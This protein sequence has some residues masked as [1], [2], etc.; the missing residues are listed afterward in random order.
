M[1]RLVFFAMVAGKASLRR[2]LRMTVPILVFLVFASLVQAQN[3]PH[4]GY[5]YTAG[6]RQG[7]TFLV[8]V[9]GQFPSGITNFTVVMDGNLAL[10]KVVG[11]DRPLK[12]ME[13]Q[14]MKEELNR[15]QEKRK[16]GERLTETELA[17]L[18]QIKR[19]L[20]Q[21]GR[22]P[23]NPAISEFMTLQLTLATNLAPGD[24][25]IRVR[26]LGGLSNPLKFCVGLLP[27]TSKPDWKALPKERG[28]MDP[29]LPPPAEATVTLPV[30]LNGQIVPGGADRYHFWA[31]QGQQLVI[32][33]E[34][35]QL[36]P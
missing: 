10:A 36:I 13:Q 14:A 31:R 28:S 17:R 8:T 21:F 23:A 29:A 26:A 30:T 4:I 32:A 15:F 22:R 7:T 34:A 2:L 3:A 1:R 5:V 20:M 18:E 19:L 16:S 25:E 24:H 27:E 33:V 6:G 11:Y 9:G 12:P 35:R